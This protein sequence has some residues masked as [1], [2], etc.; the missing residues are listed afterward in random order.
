[1]NK[2]FL[3]LLSVLTCLTFYELGK[4]HGEAKSYSEAL[5]EQ[6]GR[7]KTEEIFVC[8]YPEAF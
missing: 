6:L 2:A 8:E 5:K 3:A 4:E 7:I 1:M